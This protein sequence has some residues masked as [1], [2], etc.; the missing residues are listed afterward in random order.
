MLMTA[1]TGVPNVMY[2]NIINVYYTYILDGLE[3]EETDFSVCLSFSLSF[4]LS[5]PVRPPAGIPSP[6]SLPPVP[7][8][9]ILPK[10]VRRRRSRRPVLHRW[11][12]G[13]DQGAGERAPRG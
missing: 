6:N 9:T 13:S 2:P 10:N 1:A 5:P 8:A 3:R 12:A 4:S 11:A 7:L